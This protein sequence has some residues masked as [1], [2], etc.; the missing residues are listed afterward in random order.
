M[1]KAWT[2]VELLKTTTAFFEKKGIDSARLDAELLLAKVLG[3]RR[4]ELYLR[5]DEVVAEPQLSAFRELV[6]G[7]GARRPVK[8]LLGG[9]EF[10]SREFEVNA[11]VLVPRPETEQ[12]VEAALDRIG[13]GLQCVADIGTGCG[14]IAVVIALE[15]PEAEIYATD[16]SDSALA[17]ARRN[18][19]RHGLSERVT[20]R[21]GDLF[22]PLAGE[23]LEGRLDCIVSNPPYV[24]ESEAADLAPEVA[25]HEPHVALFSPEEGLAHVRRLLA[26][27]P[28]F[29]RGGGGMVLEIGPAV[30]DRARAAAEA[31]DAYEAVETRPDLAGKAR[32]L[33]AR[34][35]R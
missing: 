7:R 20:L 9:C 30:A 10:M 18:V 27:A 32:I 12:V 17:V 15:R 1:S 16:V 6:R 34:R 14:N 11:H 13:P 35:K 22:E 8:Q 2:V 19:E 26:G 24:A 5:F 28:A 33:I 23:G 25:E 4:I 31:N 3:C 29:L 21:S